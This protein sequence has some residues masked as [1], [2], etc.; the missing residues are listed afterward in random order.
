MVRDPGKKAGRPCKVPVWDSP[1]PDFFKV[2]DYAFLE[3]TAMPEIFTMALA[4]LP[5]ITLLLETSGAEG[6]IREHFS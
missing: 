3:E 1:I 5:G 2:N 4:Q 6:I